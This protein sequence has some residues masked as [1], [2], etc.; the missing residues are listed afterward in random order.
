MRPRRC[1]SARISS[2]N[3][4]AQLRVEIRQRLVEQKYVGPDRERA[5]NRDALLLA[6]GQLP[7][8]AFGERAQP[9]H[10]ERLAN[11]RVA[12]R[13]R[14]TPHFQT[15]RDVLRNGHVRKQRVALKHH[16]GIALVGCEPRDLGV[17]DPDFAVARLDEA[18]DHAQRRRLAAAARAEERDQFALGDIERHVGDRGRRTVLLAQI[19][20]GIPEP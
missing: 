4:D 18:R 17:A 7:G 13:L 2:R 14:Y 8:I 20:H 19:A 10:V 12:L 3:L 16:A 6:A 1:W 9:H 15:E 11:A 5:R